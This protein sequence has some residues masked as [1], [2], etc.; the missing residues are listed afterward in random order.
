M[1]QYSLTAAEQK[2]SAVR[3]TIRQR[4]SGLHSGY[5]SCKRRGIK[6]R[7]GRTRFFAIQG[8][9]DGSW[10]SLCLD[11]LRLEPASGKHRAAFFGK[12]RH[13]GRP[14]RLIGR[15]G[16]LHGSCNGCSFQLGEPVGEFLS[17]AVVAN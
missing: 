6:L 4:Y 10:Q 8:S 1:A 12:L 2:A 14:S 13:R 9:K 17:A 15:S 16:W 11:R 5:Q 3:I 7:R